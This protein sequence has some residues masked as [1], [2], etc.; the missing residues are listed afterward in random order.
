MTT[1]SYPKCSKKAFRDGLCTT[2]MPKAP[3]V[4]RPIYTWQ[5]G[6]VKGLLKPNQTFMTLCEKDT[7]AEPYKRR[8]EH[9]RLNGPTGGSPELVH[10]ILCLHDTQK[11]NNVTVW[12]SWE[13]VAM[14]VWGLGSHSGG[15]GAGNRKYT[16]TWCDG[17]NKSWSR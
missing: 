11:A 17:T 15:S 16:M 8:I 9:L 4:D 7:P 13:G 2:H 10:G 14:T 6:L 1:C 3:A 5:P 12:Y